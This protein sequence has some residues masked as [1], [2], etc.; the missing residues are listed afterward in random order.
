MKIIARLPCV[1]SVV[2]LATLVSYASAEELCA[3]D[4]LWSH[5]TLYQDGRNPYFQEFKLRGRY[6]GQ[7]WDVDAD[8]GSQSK[9]EDR[10]IRL[11]FDAKLFEKQVE[12]RLDFQSSDGFDEFY[13]GLVDAYIRWKPTDWL[14]ITAG[15]QQPK[16]AQYDWLNSNIAQPTFERSQI[17]GQLGVNRATGLTVEGNAADLTWRSGVYSND[18]PNSTGGSGAFGDGEFGDFNGGVSFTLGGGYDL[19]HLLDLDKAEVWLDW[20]HSNREEDDSVL[21]KYDDVISSTFWVKEGPATLV[22]EA[23]F[24]RGG[25]G[26]NSDVFGFSIQPTY[27]LIPKTLQLVGRYSRANS[28]GPLGVQGQARYERKV[29]GNK[30]L[31]DSYHSLYAGAQYFIYGDKLKLMAGAEWAWLDHED[32]ESYD[33]VTLLTGVRLSF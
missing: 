6:Q 8:Q 20:L 17:F 18:T 25:D 24:A 7:Y 15:R 16:I 1:G 28:E 13:D 27:D 32:G 31:G 29:A 30:G 5:A 14:S 12:V 10:R 23:F 9:W 4:K 2:L 21:G 22:I 26:T 33:G 11:G 3:F 19:R